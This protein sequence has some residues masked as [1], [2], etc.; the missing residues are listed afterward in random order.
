MTLVVAAAG[1]YAAGCFCAGYYLV[2][3][4]TGE[5]VRRSGSGTAGATNAGRRLGRLG[6]AL[7]FALDA[8]KGIAVVWVAA[9]WFDAA[10]TAAAV[11]AVVVGHVWPVQLRFRGG[12]GIATSL[13]AFAIYDPRIFGVVAALFLVSSCVRRG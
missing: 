13:G 6:F 7:T 12:K 5:D 1:G 4:W 10:A 2:R 3:W 11:V 9:H 8:L